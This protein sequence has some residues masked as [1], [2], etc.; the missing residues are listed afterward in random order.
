MKIINKLQ[1]RRETYEWKFSE[2]LS[3]NAQHCLC[4]FLV[5]IPFATFPTEARGQRIFQFVYFK[6]NSRAAEFEQRLV[7]WG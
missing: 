1:W 6:R 7:V 4:P 5:G 2:R 3:E